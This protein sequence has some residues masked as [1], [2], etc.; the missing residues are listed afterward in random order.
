MVSIRKLRKYS[1]S[2]KVVRYLGVARG[3]YQ[4]KPRVK[5]IV[6]LTIM[7]I[8]GIRI[9][10]KEYDSFKFSLLLLFTSLSKINNER[11]L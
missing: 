2:I 9:R 7:V 6:I 5:I 11:H 10:I 8:K 3:S 1:I 4:Y